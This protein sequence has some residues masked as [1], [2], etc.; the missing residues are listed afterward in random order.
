MQKMNPWARAVLV[1]VAIGFGAAAHADMRKVSFERSAATP[2][3]RIDVLEVVQQQALM[4][5]PRST[6]FEGAPPVKRGSVT[7]AI[8]NSVPAA[9]QGLLQASSKLQER[10]A[11]QDSSLGAQFTRQLVDALRAAGYDAKVLR[12]Q[13]PQ[14]NSIGRR[15]T[16]D[17][18]TSKADAVLYVVLRF[19]GYQDDAAAG[20]L[21]PM[22]GVDA[23]LFDAKDSRLLYR[24]VF[25]AG[26]KLLKDEDVE[27]PALPEQGKL[28][29][30][31]AL[32]S[33]ADA[34]ARGLVQALHPVA[35][36][37]AQQLGR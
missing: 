23:Y 4:V 2:I 9:Q 1:V 25:N 24:Q 26:Y 10:F 11:R 37:I 7:P 16:M 35:S 5:L 17:G 6:H 19:A 34:A 14:R 29:G 28:Q 15:Q 33:D 32:M 21:V 30:K 8:G 18:V 3:E 27:Y 13:H 12:G 20:G 22:A 36:R 31:A